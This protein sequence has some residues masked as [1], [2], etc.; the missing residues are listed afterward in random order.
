MV[1]VFLLWQEYKLLMT[2]PAKGKQQKFLRK[3]RFLI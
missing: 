2:L 3:M 1:W